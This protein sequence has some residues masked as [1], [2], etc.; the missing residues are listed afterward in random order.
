MKR[1]DRPER[2]LPAAPS[3]DGDVAAFLDTVARMPRSTP[4]AGRGRLMFAL[5]A[6]AS[7]QPTWDRAARL[8][9][10]M[11]VSATS[12][13]GLS[14]QVCFYRGFGEFLASPWLGD[15]NEIL[16]RMNSVTCRAGETQIG[17]VLQHALNETGRGRVA[18]LVFVGDCVE[19]DVDR[20]G[21]L[22]GQ[23]GIHGVPAFMF[24]EGS[25]AVA[26]FAFKEIARLSGGAYC[27]FD[28]GSADALRELLRAVAV[29]AAG[30]LP[31]LENLAARRG[32]DVRLLAH[33]MKRD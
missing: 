12:L 18:A 23:L 4:A 5:D 31:A 29:Y 11:F 32:G 30:G 9:S 14:V 22:A 28:A 10:E 25:N 20:L 3:A 1:P 24:H 21:S 17:K 7:R 16:R 6:T 33:Q 26:A 2:P 19:E 15:P 13:G 27:R 8:Q